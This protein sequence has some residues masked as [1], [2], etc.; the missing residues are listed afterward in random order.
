[1]LDKKNG[2]TRHILKTKENFKYMLII[3]GLVTGLIAG[4]IAVVYRICLEKSESFVYDMGNFI[5]GNIGYIIVWILFLLG[6]GLLVARLLKIEPFISGSG[7][8]QVEGEI[9][10]FLDQ[11]WERVLPLKFVSGI[12][13][14]LGGLSLG[15]EG[16]SIQLG[17]MA[18]KGIAKIF[19][20]V[21]ME[22]KLLLTCGAAAG[23]SAAFNAPLAGV[24][25]ALE[26]LH[27]NF[28]VSVLVC[29]MC[30]SVS[31][32]FISQNIFGLEPAFHFIVNETL[33]LHYY[34][35]ILLIG[36]ITGLF[37]V[38]Y[39]K[40]TISVQTL[41]DKVNPQVRIVIPFMMAGV[42]LLVLPEVLGGGHQMI[43]LISGHSILLIQSA[44]LL[45]VVK[46]VFSLVSFGAG[47]PGGIFFPMLVLGSFIGVIF[48]MIAV[49]Y[50][51]LPKMYIANFIILAM[52]GTFSAIV[53]SPITGII[54]IAEMTGT[55][56]HMLPLAC[57]SLVA[58]ICASMLKSEP[59]YE[60]LLH[61]IL[62][63]NGVNTNAFQGERHMVDSVVELGSEVCDHS[64]REIHWPNKC[65]IISIHRNGK[66]ILPNGD[67][68]LRCG[69][70]LV[71]L[72]EDID[73]P[74]IQH[75]LEKCCK[76]KF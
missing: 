70:T 76:G 3:E 47:A 49:Q 75:E 68:L 21:K 19:R 41:L 16:P 27:K 6:L 38:V 48:G 69:D 9:V 29:V 54:L 37:G 23:L 35:M 34:G 57:V 28:S 43:Q 74:Y 67:T 56:S 24:M 42:L 50:F 5:R 2:S 59:I 31:G 62:T 61:K 8:P 14:A 15:R 52:A 13:C 26:E 30:A 73:T 53:R 55:L 39:N 44:L 4:L 64:V 33:P 1:M 63:K 36:V 12:L 46:F 7:I 18:G 51:G 45:L 17:A 11:K 71:A 40:S 20:R 58:Y 65:L 66:E 32:D 72:L 25:F 60:S 10:S 22:E